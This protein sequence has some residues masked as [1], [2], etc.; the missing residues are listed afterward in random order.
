MIDNINWYLQSMPIPPMAHTKDKIMENNFKLLETLD[1][2][3]I[4]FIS[5]LQKWH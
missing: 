1:L 5:K 4:L 2:P 3:S